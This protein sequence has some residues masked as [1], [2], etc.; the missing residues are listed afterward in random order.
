VQRQTQ[1]PGGMLLSLSEFEICA[2]FE[3]EQGLWEGRL[4]WVCVFLANATP[5]NL[6]EVDSSGKGLVFLWHF[7]L[8][9]VLVA[10]L[11]GIKFRGH[12]CRQSQSLTRSM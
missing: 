6:K 12:A 9:L 2:V 4:G 7:H 3:T 1:G 5:T 8:A 10:F 11:S